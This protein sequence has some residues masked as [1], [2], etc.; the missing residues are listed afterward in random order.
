MIILCEEDVVKCLP[1]VNT[2]SQINL[3]NT[4][5]LTFLYNIAI[6]MRLCTIRNTHLIDIDWQQHTLILSKIFENFFIMT[7]ALYLPF[8]FISGYI[9]NYKWKCRRN[10]TLKKTIGENNAWFKLFRQFIFNH[11]WS[12]RWVVTSQ[13]KWYIYIIPVCI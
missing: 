11:R 12:V 8:T 2:L 10:E 4:F 9:W 13:N 5:Q 7:V 1:D 6:Y 3:L